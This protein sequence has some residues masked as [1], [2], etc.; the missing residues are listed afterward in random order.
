MDGKAVVTIS[1]DST[2]PQVALMV[3]A[4]L[5]RHGIRAVLT[6]GACVSIYTD[7]AYVSQDA[8]FVIQAAPA[9][10]QQ[11]VDDALAT[12][13]FVRKN[14]RYVHARTP[15]YVEFPPGPLS[16]GGDLDIRPVARRG[17]RGTALLLSPTDCCR[18]RLAA[19]Y[20]WNDRQSLEHAVDV[21]RHRDVDLRVVK[22]WSIAERSSDEYEEF[23]RE[24]RSRKAS[25]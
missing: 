17:G 8:D 23:L 14:D 25:E 12:L 24:L 10:L 5:T 13:G 9:R 16:I 2:L 22:A 20:F 3:G 7:G 15:F 19:F 11:K 4:A 21:A 6:G 1:R 18:D